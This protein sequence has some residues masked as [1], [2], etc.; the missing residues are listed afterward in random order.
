M[1]DFSDPP[2]PYGI[3]EVEPPATRS[4][5]ATA[6][7]SDHVVRAALDNLKFKIINLKSLALCFPV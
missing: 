1:P 4:T 3:Q 5:R 6:P 7:A 2:G